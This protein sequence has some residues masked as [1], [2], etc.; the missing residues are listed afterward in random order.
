M[1][2]RQRSVQRRQKTQKTRRSQKHL[3]KFHMKH[4]RWLWITFLR[5]SRWAIALLGLAGGAAWSQTVAAN[6]GLLGMHQ[7][8]LETSLAGVQ[9]VRS[10]RRLSSGAVGF[11][12]VPNALFERQ[13]FEEILFFA[14]Q[15]LVQIELLPLHAEPS[16]FADL[17]QSLRGQLGPELAASSSTAHLLMD[18]A[19]WVWGDADVM[20]FRSGKPEHPVVRLVIKQRQLVDANAL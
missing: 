1:G 18:T 7:D 2:A 3:T 14:H 12:R 15:K 10:P 13:Q 19:S 16:A 11:L 5:H 8:R 6:V 17:A 9:P 20:L 4:P